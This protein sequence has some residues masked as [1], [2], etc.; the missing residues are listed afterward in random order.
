MKDMVEFASRTGI[1][2]M[3]FKLDEKTWKTLMWEKIMKVTV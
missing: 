3:V 1:C 2:M